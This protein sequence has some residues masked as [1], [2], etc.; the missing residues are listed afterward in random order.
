M[1]FSLIV[2]ASVAFCRNPNNKSAFYRA[3]NL[4]K[5]L[6]VRGFTY[7]TLFS[8]V[9]LLNIDLNTI[10]ISDAYLVHRRLLPVN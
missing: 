9:G 8:F 3:N 1:P 10:E 7:I 5:L 4:S 2:P 6:K